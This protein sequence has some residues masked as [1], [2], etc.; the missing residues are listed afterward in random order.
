MNLIY[1]LVCIKFFNRTSS[2]SIFFILIFWRYIL[3]IYISFGSVIDSYLQN[4]FYSS[5]NNTKFCSSTLNRFLK[6]EPHHLDALVIR[7]HLSSSGVTHVWI[8]KDWCDKKAATIL[9]VHKKSF[10]IIFP[11]FD[12][13]TTI[14]LVEDLYKNPWCNLIHNL[15]KFSF[16]KNLSISM[17]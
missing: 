1:T 12:C 7:R 17:H 5:Q 10:S 14:F 6:K 11:S 8:I 13:S 2:S 16:M 15:I 4:P 9:V 3:A